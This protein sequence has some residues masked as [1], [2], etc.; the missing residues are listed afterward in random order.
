MNNYKASNN[1]KRNKH[2]CHHPCFNNYDYH[3]AIIHLPVASQDNIEYKDASL[4]CRC[5]GIVVENDKSIV[6]SPYEAYEQ[7]VEAKKSIPILSVAAIAG[8]GETLAD[9]DVVKETF[10]FIRQ[11]NQ[12]INL[13]L[14][15]N[16]L[17]LPVYANHLIS[18][19]VNYITVHVNTNRPETGANL[20]HHITYMGRKYYGEEGANILLQNQI[21]GMSYLSSMGIA[22]RMNISVVEGVNDHEIKDIVKLAK[23]CG[24]KLTN[25]IPLTSIKNTDFNGMESYSNDELSDLRGEC[26]K[27]MPQSYYCKPCSYASVETLNT[28][29]SIDFNNFAREIYKD[30]RS[31]AVHYRFAV[32]SKNGTLTD[33][34]FGHATKF[35]IYDYN[36]EEVTFI[37][38]R[39]IEQYS[40]G[41]KDEKA[42]GRIYRLIKYIED[43][44]CVICMR[45]GVCPSDALKEKNIE[46]YTTY[47]LIED[48]IKEAVKRLYS[49]LPIDLG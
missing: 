45:I 35:Y 29:L 2:V 44:N 37:E 10:K 34:H 18:M 13:C 5:A 31:V 20:Y 48:G 27:I 8:P 3:S 28:R 4:K 43:C 22:V 41:T 11:T 17:M 40:H 47:N 46:V 36:G 16:G 15:T 25:I 33:Q 42:A 12:D 39:T 26:E 30:R 6:L 21:N 19:G 24:C 49:G 1:H 14:S 38:T 7:F 23:E 9:F 32:C